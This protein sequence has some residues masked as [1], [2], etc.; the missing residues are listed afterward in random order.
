MLIVENLVKHFPV[1]QPF[2]DMLRR[3]PLNVIRAVDGVSFSVARGEVLAIVGESGCGKTTIARTL[4]GLE[5]QTAGTILFDGQSVGTAERRARAGMVPLESGQVGTREQQTLP[6]M[7]LKHLRQHAQMIFQDP[8]ESLNPRATIFEIVAEPLVVHGLA[9]KREERIARV[10]SALEDAGLRPAEDYF[11]RYP[12]E[13]SGGQRQ[14]VVIAGAMVLRPQLLI[15]DE[16][17]SMLDVSIRAEILNLLRDLQKSLGVG[18]VFITHD[19]STVA[20]FA[21]RIAV[22]YLGRIVESGLTAEVLQNPQHPYTKALLSVAPVPNP[23]LRRERII[24]QGETPNPANIPSGCRFHPRCPV[25]VDAC[26]LTDP[27][28]VP[29]SETHQAACFLVAP[30]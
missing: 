21:D 20:Y 15:A 4:I 30:R 11:L 18:I 7:S 27:G 26:K 9:R 10:K 19:L 14:R 29:V 8:Y 2:W 23:R 16:P 25:A 22:M 24:L 5:E 13:L 28:Y 6:R 1:A 3:R 12:H 17:V